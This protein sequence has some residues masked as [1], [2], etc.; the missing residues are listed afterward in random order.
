MNFGS[1]LR[2]F[3]DK[4]GIDQQEF[5]FDIRMDPGNLSKII[6]TPRTPTDKMLEKLE[7]PDSGLTLAVLRRWRAEAQYPELFEATNAENL[8]PPEGFYRFPCRGQ[9][10]AGGLTL[11]EE[12]EDITYYEWIGV[13]EYSS[14]M[15]CLKV[16]GDSM[17]PTIPDGAI[18]LVR[19]A[20]SY[21]PGRIYVFQT[22][23]GETTL[24]LLRVATDG[25]SLVPINGNHS[26]I[27][28]SEMNITKAFEVIEHKVSYL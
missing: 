5:A 21:S 26:P 12:P 8:G 4:E 11:Q 1:K 15:F 9:V 14:D 17:E 22:E 18:V 23:D 25:V 3:L 27:K 7:K 16:R 2:D 28:V 10:T 19:P 24:K 13:P 6:N 20:K